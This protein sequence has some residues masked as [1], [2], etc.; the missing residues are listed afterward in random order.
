MNLRVQ[1][2]V[3]PVALLSKPKGTSST[4][5]MKEGVKKNPSALK[6]GRD[7]ALQGLGYVFSERGEKSTCTEAVEFELD[8][9]RR[10]RL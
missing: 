2:L 6:V 7:L 10:K 1:L 4:P 5:R 9:L 8:F 3:F